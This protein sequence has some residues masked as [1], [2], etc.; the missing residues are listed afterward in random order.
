M[1]KSQG[2]KY[3]KTK[4]VSN[5]IGKIIYIELDWNNSELQ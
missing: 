1:G 3:G 2:S 5:T 4:Q